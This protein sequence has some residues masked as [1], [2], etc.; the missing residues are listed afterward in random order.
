M[1]YY[2]VL[3]CL[4]YAMLYLI[5]YVQYSIFSHIILNIITSCSIILLKI[6]LACIY[7]NICLSISLKAVKE[8]KA[9]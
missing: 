4:H 3:H 2:V 1:L 5:Y 6:V 7:A 9:V 8:N